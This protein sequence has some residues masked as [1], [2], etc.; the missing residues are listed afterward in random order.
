MNKI[1]IAILA[2]ALVGVG[3]II[4]QEKADENRGLQFATIAQ[5]SPWIPSGMKYT[6]REEALETKNKNLTNFYSDHYKRYLGFDGVIEKWLEEYKGF[7]YKTED[8]ETYNTGEETTRGGEYR[9]AGVDNDI[10][11]CIK[12]GDC[13]VNF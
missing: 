4:I 2:I 1:I 3:F 5:A 10:Y 8:G 12:Y 11:K 13:K 9:S 6:P 7:V